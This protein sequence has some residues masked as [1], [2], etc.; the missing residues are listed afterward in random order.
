MMVW[1]QLVY[2]IL[3]GK[4]LVNVQVIVFNFVIGIICCI[5]VSVDGSYMLIGLQLG[6]YQV[7]VGLGMQQNVMFMVV[8]MFMLNFIVVMVEVL[9]I[10]N[11]I[12]FGSVMVLVIILQEVKILE[13]GGI[14]FL[15]QIDMIFQVF[16]NF[17]E[18]VDIVFGMVFM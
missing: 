2:V 4:V 6:I 12:N 16:C 11:V 13:V 8:L 14:I 18:F 17:F 1:S 3:C 7:D 5:M 15:Y 9:L 10:I